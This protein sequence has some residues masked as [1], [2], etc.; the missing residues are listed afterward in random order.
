MFIDVVDGMEKEKCWGVVILGREI[1][2][3]G[4]DGDSLNLFE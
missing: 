1:N 2:F 3:D 4:L